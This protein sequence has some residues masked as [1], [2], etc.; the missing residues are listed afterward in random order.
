MGREAVG[1]KLAVCAQVEGSI[2]SIYS[3]KGL[4]K[5]D[6]EIRLTLKTTGSMAPELMEWIKSRH[7]YE[8][9]E[10]LGCPVELVDPDY[11]EWANKP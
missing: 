4:L 7:P 2:V 5:Q 10:I 3:W 8:V 11:L 6:P 9:P 1:G